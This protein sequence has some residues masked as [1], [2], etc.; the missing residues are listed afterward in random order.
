[1]RQIILCADTGSEKHFLYNHKE[2]EKS[3]GDNFDP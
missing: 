3:D 2:R 1:M